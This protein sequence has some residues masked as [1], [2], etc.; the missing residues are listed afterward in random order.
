MKV[1]IFGA[2]GAI[3]GLI[4]G[5]AFGLLIGIAWINVFQTSEFEGYSATLVFFAFVPAGAVIGGI[6]GA[7]WSALASS[8][9]KIRVEPDI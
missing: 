4:V 1:L 9:A 3:A 7:G 5:A 8:R 2:L 6:I